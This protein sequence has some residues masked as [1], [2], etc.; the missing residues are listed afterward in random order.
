LIVVID[1]TVLIY[2]FDSNANAPLDTSTGLP[3]SE[4]AKR[5][6]YLIT[7]LSRSNVTL[8]VPTPVLAEV[9]IRAGSAGPKWL[10]VLEKNKNVR[11]SPFDTMAA[12]ECSAMARQRAATTGN[13][14]REKSKFD[15]QIVAI[16]RVNGATKYLSDDSD[17]K[18]LVGTSASVEGILDLP[19]PPTDPQGSLGLAI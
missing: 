5:V 11:I 18:K 8:V 6:D 17:I 2:L 15:E 4:C 13:A 19:L 1:A 12:V 10:Q 16:G 7:E 3:V 14:A 9:L